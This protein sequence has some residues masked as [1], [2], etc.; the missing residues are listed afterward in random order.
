M[1]DIR[2][3]PATAAADW[4]LGGVRLLRRSPT[5]LGGLGAILGALGLVAAV[6]AQR[7][8]DATLALAAQLAFLLIG[9][10]LLAGMI[11]AAREV[12]E[13][14]GATP[15]HLL[16]GLREGKALRLIGTLLPQVAAF[17]LCAFALIALLGPEGTQQVID[18][19]RKLQAQAAPNPADF[20]DLPVL[21]LALWF[22]LLGGAMFAVWLLTFLAIPDMILGD[23]G[24]VAGLRN[25]ARA[26]LRN[27]MALL[28]FTVLMLIVLFALVIA[29]NLVGLL[30]QT[31]LGDLIALAA[32]QIAMNA[33]LMPIVTGAMYLAWKQILGGDAAGAPPAVRHIEV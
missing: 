23:R 5:G 16:A 28:L 32:V 29:V 1:T 18:A 30:L 7:G 15:A 22:L 11:H 20:R 3:V 10:L 9:P 17:A 27:P 26:A 12:D 8:G 4:L 24:L 6:A 19:S 21:R 13:G 31:L 25:S 2:H 33:V 14:R